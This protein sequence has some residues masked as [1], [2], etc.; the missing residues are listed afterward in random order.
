MKNKIRKKRLKTVFKNCRDLAETFVKKSQSFGCVKY[1]PGGRWAG[2]NRRAGEKAL[3]KEM[4]CYF[5]KDRLYSFGEHYLL[6][7]LDLKINGETVSI[8]NY[9]TYSQTTTGHSY[10]AFYAI[11]ATRRTIVEINESVFDDGEY[12]NSRHTDADI[13]E[14][15]MQAI[16]NKCFS[17]SEDVLKL[18]YSPH[19]YS[20]WLKHE[21]KDH[22]KLCEKLKL[23]KYKVSVPK[24]YILI[25]RQ[26]SKASTKAYLSHRSIQQTK[27]DGF[28]R[29]Y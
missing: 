27:L 29:Y 11:Q 19:E 20:V 1:T 21:I 22:N 17:L 9:K 12:L 10:D 13:K 18:T 28:S 8:V 4:S 16:K 23:T 25:N 26:L 15:A 3:P 2:Y 24:E 6:A 14:L 7:V 5:K